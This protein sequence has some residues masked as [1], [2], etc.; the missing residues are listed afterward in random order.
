MH[1]M[2]TQKRTKPSDSI[3]SKAFNVTQKKDQA[4]IRNDNYSKKDQAKR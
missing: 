4:M 2:S 3:N 1:F